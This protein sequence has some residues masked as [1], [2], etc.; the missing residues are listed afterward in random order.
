M[1]RI[2]KICFESREQVKMSMNPVRILAFDDIPE[3]PLLLK[4]F[5]SEYLLGIAGAMI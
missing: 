2:Q 4:H 5:P 3:I 1:A